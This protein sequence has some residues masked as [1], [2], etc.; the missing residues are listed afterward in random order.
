LNKIGSAVS[1]KFNP[2]LSA[3]PGTESCYGADLTFKIALFMQ[4]VLQLKD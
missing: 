2:S 3:A 1:I 4:M